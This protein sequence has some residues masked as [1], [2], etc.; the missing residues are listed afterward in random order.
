MQ[1]QN[2]GKVT[3]KSII[4]DSTN[5]EVPFATV[6]LLTPKDSTLVNFTTSDATGAFSFN[7]VRNIPYL[8]KISHISYLPH[9]QLIPVSTTPVNDLGVIRVKPISLALMEVVV[10]AAKAPLKIRGIRLNTM[11]PLS[12]FR[13]DPQWKIFCDDFPGSK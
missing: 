5:A 10:R 1:A 13:P 8:L 6:M 9:Q 2:P 12:R 7:N 11:P 4:R 3:I